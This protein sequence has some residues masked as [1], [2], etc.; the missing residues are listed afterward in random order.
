MLIPF[1]FLPYVSYFPLLSFLYY[2][3]PH[4]YFFYSSLF[5]IILFFLFF[6]FVKPKMIKALNSLFNIFLKS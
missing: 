4:L 2:K 6:I 3:F 1:R 5:I